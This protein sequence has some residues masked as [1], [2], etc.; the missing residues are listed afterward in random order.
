MA[1]QY[2][3]SLPLNCRTNLMLL[4]GQR[5]VASPQCFSMQQYKHASLDF[6]SLRSLKVKKLCLDDGGE[7]GKKI[8][9]GRTE[10]LANSPGERERKGKCFYLCDFLAGDLAPS[11]QSRPASTGYKN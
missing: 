7:T 1:S 8:F 9:G 5:V 11:M 6:A 10:I 4:S 3:L 2:R